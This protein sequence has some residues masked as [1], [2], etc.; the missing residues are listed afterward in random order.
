LKYARKVSSPILRSMP[1]RMQH[2][3]RPKRR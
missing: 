3:M 1:Q 2:A